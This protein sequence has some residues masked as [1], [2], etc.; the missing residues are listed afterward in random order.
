[1]P[2]CVGTDPAGSYRWSRHGLPWRSNGAPQGTA[3]DQVQRRW[4]TAAELRV[5]EYVLMLPSQ[6]YALAVCVRLY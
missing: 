1:M 2:I 6:G 4:S 5:A 3:Y